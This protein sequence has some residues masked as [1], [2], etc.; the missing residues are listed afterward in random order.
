MEQFFTVLNQIGIFLILIFVGVLTVKFGIL[1]ERSLGNVSKLVMRVA[2]PAYI[3]INTV[4]GAT[5]QG[6][7][8]SLMMIPLSALL[9]L[10]VL[11]LGLLLARLFHL[12]GNRK[13]IFRAI[14]TF[15]NVGFMGIPLV[16]EL[17][18]DTALVYISLFTILDQSL[19]W[20]YGV[21]LTRG[22]ARKQEKLSFRGLKNLLSPALIAIL[23]GTVLVLLGIHLPGVITASLN[24]LGA[25]S[26]PFSLIYVGGMLSMTDIRRVLRCG[27]LYGEILLKM[28]VLPLL[29]Y[30][31]MQC[32][33]V[34]GDM[35]GTVTFLMGLPAISTVA[36]LARQ[37][38]S[39]GDYAI[40]AVM[41]TTLASLVTLP[42]VSL[43][44]SLMG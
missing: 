37:N 32:I 20:T 15:G 26:M 9:Y 31:L 33:G 22:Q 35:A 6:L 18:P 28:L 1:D 41:L 16:V 29:Y 43:G 2:L 17:Y 13:N 10:L 14:C 39:D 24:R 11:L 19:F 40:C 7:L 25:A 21:S 4:D 38:G 5:R 44:I 12:E 3:F 36:M 8:D 27:E 30:F 34:P 23:L 42:L